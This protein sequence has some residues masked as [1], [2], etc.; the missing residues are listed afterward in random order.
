MADSLK[1]SYVGNY[2][3][4]NCQKGQVSLPCKAM[5]HTHKSLYG[6]QFLV[7]GKDTF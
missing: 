4:V 3:I 1:S 7:E 2:L 5:A 6:T